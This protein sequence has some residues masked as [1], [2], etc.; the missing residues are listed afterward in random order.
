MLTQ[1]IFLFELVLNTE[2]FLRRNYG[3]QLAKISILWEKLVLYQW[4]AE[5]F[6]IFTFKETFC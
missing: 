6:P 1:I 5:D 3:S 2:T 4:L